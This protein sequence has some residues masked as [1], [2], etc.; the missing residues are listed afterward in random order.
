MNT[1]NTSTKTVTILQREGRAPHGW[2]IKSSKKSQCAH[3]MLI[4]YGTVV[5]DFDGAYFLPNEVA[6]ELTAK[7]YT[8]PASLVYKRNSAINGGINAE[9]GR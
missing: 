8:V 3:G 2:E 9:F 1:S 5:E 4:C 7:G 6:E